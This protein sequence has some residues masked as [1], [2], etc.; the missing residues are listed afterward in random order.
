MSASPKFAYVWEYFVRGDKVDEFQS[1]YGPTGSWAKLFSRSTSYFRTAPYRD[2]TNPRRF[3]TTD[4][5][6][7][8]EARDQFRIEVAAEFAI[9]DEE[10]DKLTE[11]EH[12][13]GDFEIV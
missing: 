3:V 11:S 2:V 6:A 4:F 1:M 12:F 5:W 8:K 9:L 7:S 13:I 10:G